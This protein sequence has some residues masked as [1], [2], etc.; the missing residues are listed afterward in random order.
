MKPTK[1]L[2][3][4]VLFGLLQSLAIVVRPWPLPWVLAFGA[5][6]AKRLYVLDRRRAAHAR[7]QIQ[8]ALGMAP[9]EADRLA[10]LSYA[11]LGQLV[12]EVM[13]LP[14]PTFIR[15]WVELSTADRAVL[16]DAVGEGAGAIL[17]TGHIGNWEL[18]AQ[19]IVAEGIDGVTVVRSAPNPYIGRWLARIRAEGG[20]EAIGRGTRSTPRAV[21]AALRRGALVGLLIDQKTDLPSVEVPFFGRPAPTPIAAAALA[22]RKGC[23]IVVATIQRGSAGR[24]RIHVARLERHADDGVREVTARLS[25]ALENAIRQAPEQW[26]WLHDRWNT[27]HFGPS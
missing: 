5:F 19:R 25:K 13:R 26:I 21:L 16:L 27:Q 4:R 8:N 9:K 10:A 1:W 14:S 17:V 23:P 3:R 2:K 15:D 12:I 11:H 22:L 7:L 24:H 20:I 6:V 18:L